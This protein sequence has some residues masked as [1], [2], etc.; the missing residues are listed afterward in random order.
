MQYSIA[1]RSAAYLSCKHS[2]LQI[3]KHEEGI[4]TIPIEDIGM[5]TIDH[6]AV[7]ITE[8]LITEISKN[9]ASILCCGTNHIPEAIILPLVGNCRQNELISLQFNVKKP[10]Q[11]QQWKSIVSAKIYN[12]SLCLEYLNLPFHSVRK[13]IDKI[14]S[15]DATN[16]EAVAAQAYFKILITDGSRRDSDWT[17]SLDYGYSIIRS[18]IIQSLITH[19]LMPSKGIHHNSIENTFNLADDLVEPFRP[20]VDFYI[21]SYNLNAELSHEIKASLSKVLELCVR[22]NGRKISVRQSIDE[23]IES[24]IRS[25]KEEDSSILS[26]PS[27]LPIELITFE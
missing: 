17:P 3:D 9:K 11:K 26:C 8:R 16:R 23:L 19:G 1:I 25:M 5:I 13:L 4:I 22:H 7:V 2:Q 14:Q 15:D 24:L 20:V 27:L 10:L 12:Q 21:A 6:P 18:T